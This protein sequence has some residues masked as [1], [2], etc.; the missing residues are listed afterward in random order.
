MDILGIVLIILGVLLTILSPRIQGPRLG[1]TG[2]RVRGVAGPILMILGILK[3][4]DVM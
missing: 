3:L 2:L 4:V 1:L